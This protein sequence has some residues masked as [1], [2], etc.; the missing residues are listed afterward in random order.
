ML[1]PEIV[2]EANWVT[3]IF[4]R[5]PAQFVPDEINNTGQVNEEIKKLLRA[6]NGELSKNELQVKLKLKHR[7][8]FTH[9]ERV[10]TEDNVIFNILFLGDL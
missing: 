10:S 6:C 7:D 1:L 5:N 4:K 8:Y 3:I 2:V 9:I